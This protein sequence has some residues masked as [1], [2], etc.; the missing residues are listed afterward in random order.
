MYLMIF[1]DSSG[2]RFMIGNS[3]EKLEKWAKKNNIQNYDIGS[4]T[5]KTIGKK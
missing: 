2:N 4:Y 5:Y 1:N 3:K